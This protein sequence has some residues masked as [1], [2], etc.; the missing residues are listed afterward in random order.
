MLGV[1][2]ANA[3][4]GGL[5]DLG[6]RVARVRSNTIGAPESDGKVIVTDAVSRLGSNEHL[7]QWFDL[8]AR[9]KRA[10]ALGKKLLGMRQ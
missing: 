9:K 8:T 5:V 1:F 4:H 2:D 6:S 7:S 3:L 10:T